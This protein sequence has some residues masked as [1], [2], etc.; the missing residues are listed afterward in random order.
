V[1]SKAGK[2][3]EGLH[4]VGGVTIASKISINVVLNL[5]VMLVCD[6]YYII[7]HFVVMMLIVDFFNFV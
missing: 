7:M 5:Y 3:M 1:W 4:V 6:T 2:F